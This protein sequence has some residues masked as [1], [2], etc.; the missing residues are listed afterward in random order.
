MPHATPAAAQA[1]PGQVQAKYEPTTKF[2]P[3]RDMLQRHK[4]LEKAQVLMSPLR[5]PRAITIRA[6][7]CSA[8]ALPYDA[9]K[10]V[11]TICYEAIASILDLAKG[12]TSDADKLATVVSGGII[13]ETLHRVAIA[14]LH[15]YDIPVWGKEEDA[16]DL[17]G[18]F[19]M[20][21]FDEHAAE[22]AILGAGNLFIVKTSSVGKVDYVA[23]VSPP[24]QRL[25]NFLCIA[26]GGDPIDF[27]GLVDKGFLPKDRAVRCGGEYNSIRK[28]F[29]LRVMP[30]VD[31]DLVVKIRAI[32]WLH[33][34]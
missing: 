26:V 3:V 6:T 20:L 11:I 12:A 13:E 34:D 8:P 32:D 5:L 30:H 33:E 22:V 2:A 21:Q 29:D 18:A 19:M 25:Y 28:A 4:V 9:A 14:I 15:V 31:P 23:D 24:A 7:E 16:A 27:G 10:G 17:L 1:A